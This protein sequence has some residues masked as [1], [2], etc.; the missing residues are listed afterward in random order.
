MTISTNLLADAEEQSGL[1]AK[2]NLF[3]DEMTAKAIDGLSLTEFVELL[4]AAM[5]ICIE[6]LET[7]M[8]DGPNRKIVV[9]SV[10]QTLFDRFSDSVVPIYLLPAWWIIKPAF[11]SLCLSLA[12]GT[13]EVLLPLIRKQN[14]SPKT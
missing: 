2:V 8:L 11:R 9:L 1:A 5:R 7:M 6:S 3:I 10:V 14:E 4:V 12:A 13:V